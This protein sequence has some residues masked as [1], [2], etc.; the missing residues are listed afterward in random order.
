[1]IDEPI[2]PPISVRVL[3]NDGFNV[4]EGTVGDLAFVSPWG[5]SMEDFYCLIRGITAEASVLRH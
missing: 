2:S 4:G 5:C 1:M 3:D